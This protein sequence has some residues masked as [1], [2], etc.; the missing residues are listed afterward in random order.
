MASREKWW[1]LSQVADYLLRKIHFIFLFTTFFL[2]QS[3]GGELINMVEVKNCPNEAAISTLYFTLTSYNQTVSIGTANIKI[4]RECGDDLHLK[5]EAKRWNEED[6]DYAINALEFK[7]DKPCA[8]MF[9]IFTNLATRFFWSA[10]RPVQCPFKKGP[11]RF[12]PRYPDVNGIPFIFNYGRYLIKLNVRDPAEDNV[13]VV[14]FHM[15]LNVVPEE[16]ASNDSEMDD[17]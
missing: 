15:I 3:N 6:H 17:I 1:G 13:L 14:C 11:I 8:K 9:N 10:G 5:V 12:A 16:Q 7:T 4:D 2:L